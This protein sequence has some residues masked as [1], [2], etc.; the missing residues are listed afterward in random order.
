MRV[1]CGQRRERRCVRAANAS[2]VVGFTYSYGGSS[3][4][5]YYSYAVAADGN[6]GYTFTYTTGEYDD[7]GEM[8]CA[9]GD[10][11]LSGLQAIYD[12]CG[13]AAWN[14]YNKYNSNVLDGY[15]FSVSFTFAD[16]GTMY[17][18]G[19]NSSPQGYRMF[20]DKMQ[21]LLSPLADDLC[22]QARQEHIG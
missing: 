16:G 2:G 17:A 10:D 8:T 9:V 22:E 14:G 19:S 13:L 18:Q 11:V 15:G 3:A 1:G 7:Y 4:Y 20:V 12:E 6:G 5:S 21:E